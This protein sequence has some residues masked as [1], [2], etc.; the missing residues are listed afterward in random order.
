VQKKELYIQMLIIVGRFHEK[1][2]FC[3]RKTRHLPPVVTADVIGGYPVVR[4]GLRGRRIRP[5]EVLSP[6][7]KRGD[8]LVAA[9]ELGGPFPWQQ[10]QVAEYAR[11]LCVNLACHTLKQA[12]ARHRTTALLVD[13]EG[14]C[15]GVAAELLNITTTLWVATRRPERYDPC[16]HYTRLTLGTTPLFVGDT[17]PSARAVIAPYGLGGYTYQGGELFSPDGGLFP[18][19]E[20]LYIPPYAIEQKVDPLYLTA[21]LFTAFYPKELM[22]ALPDRNPVGEPPLLRGYE[23]RFSQPFSK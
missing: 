9:E 13:Q 19:P 18:T 16:V 4:L 23:N 15:T 6:Y 12:E 10:E 11:R 7:L 22:E 8:V 20:Q 5:A 21:G 1:R 14:L 17:L 3:L 2:G